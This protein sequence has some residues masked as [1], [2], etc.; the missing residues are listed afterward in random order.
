MK[1]SLSLCLLLWF[2]A[3][4]SQP[5]A[6]PAAGRNLL[7]ELEQLSDSLDKQKQGDRLAF[8]RSRLDAPAYR[9]SS[10]ALAYL[11][12]QVAKYLVKANADSAAYHIG[13]ALE[14]ADAGEPVP[15]L[16]FAICNGAG[17]IAEAQAKFYLAGYYYNESAAIITSTDSLDAK[18]LS[19]AVCLLSAAQYNNKVS[20]SGKAAA[21]NRMALQLLQQMP[22]PSPRHI[23]RAY[24]QLFAA[25]SDG[26]LFTTDSLF[27]C[28]SAMERWAAASEDSLQRR[29][30]QEHTA[31]YY[32]KTQRFDSAVH[33]YE[34]VK[35]FDENSLHNKAPNAIRNLYITLSNLADLYIRSGQLQ[36]AAAAIRR[37]DELDNQYPGKLA[38]DEKVLGAKAVM[39]LRFAAGDRAGAT[40]AAGDLY[41]LQQ[42]VIRN[43][44]VLANEEM[45]S[46]Y[47][48]RAKD[49]SIA[50]LNRQV[51]FAAQRIE[52]NRLL[53]LVIALLALLAVSWALMIYFAQKQKR[54]LQE[55]ENVLLQ[56]QLLRAQME[57]HFI[58]NTLSALQ[59]FIRFDEKEKSIHYLSQFSKLLRSNLELSRQQYVPL[60]DELEAIG[61]YL[62]LQQMRYEEAFH[63]NI[64]A[65]EA[66]TDMLLIPPM[67]IQPFVEN[68]ILH[69]ISST[70]ANGVVTVEVLACEKQVV[71]NITDNGKG[72]AAGRNGKSAHKSL[73]GAIARERLEIL[74]KE[75]GM[76]AGLD[77]VSGDGGTTVRLTL[78]VKSAL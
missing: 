48:L 31:Y 70:A 26:G 4:R 53:L 7:P 14:L 30:L 1:N 5:G 9:H 3:C 45:E 29:F 43:A 68:A 75:K 6:S 15:R 41:D 56:Q 11:H 20:Q 34:Q 13:R 8:W 38:G 42:G 54:A 74:A 60:S 36:Q 73:S 63:Y 25:G 16:K 59:S 71:V 21:Q 51:D 37:A 46:V 52:N 2:C 33:F 57:P 35:A 62:S 69:G 23:F 55:R 19:K 27:V 40:K 44:G 64:I 66:D 28:L 49:R 78:P 39:H 18:P 24:S 61:H 22:V 67:L 72:M 47:Q 32:T 58:F 10:E 17:I 65:P 76:Q 12:Y 50:S 77:I